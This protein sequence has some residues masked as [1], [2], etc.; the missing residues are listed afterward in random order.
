MEMVRGR[1]RR[2]ERAD[3]PNYAVTVTTSEYK[4]SRAEAQPVQPGRHR[5]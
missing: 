5:S 1:E 2:K 4:A 3:G